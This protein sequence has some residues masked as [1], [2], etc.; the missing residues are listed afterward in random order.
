M[1]LPQPVFDDGKVTLYQGDALRLLQELESASTLDAARQCGRR[2]IGIE[3]D[4][5]WCRL[6]ASRL[7][8]Q[9]LF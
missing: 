5:R 9:W 7:S 2:A 8:Q 3:Q 6:G 4:A 1:G